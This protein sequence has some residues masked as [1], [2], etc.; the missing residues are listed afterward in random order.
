MESKGK[1][2]NELADFMGWSSAEQFGKW[3]RG[4]Y[5]ISRQNAIR[6]AEFLHVGLDELDPSGE[7]FD[8]ENRGPQRRRPSGKLLI[9]NVRDIPHSAPS[10][11]IRTTP[12]EGATMNDEPDPGGRDHA[13]EAILGLYNYLYARVKGDPDTLDLIVNDFEAAIR[14]RLEERRKEAAKK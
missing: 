2:Q 4:A 8:M 5:R 10:N 13:R 1:T 14:L 7:S 6:L 3:R 9:D 12:T 11:R